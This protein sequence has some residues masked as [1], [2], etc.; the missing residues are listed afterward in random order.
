MQTPSSSACPLPT[1]LAINPFLACPQA[2]SETGTHQSTLVDGGDARQLSEHKVVS[3]WM[4]IYAPRMI[5][6]NGVIRYIA[7]SD[8]DLNP[9]EAT[10]RDILYKLVQVMSAVSIMKQTGMSAVEYASS[11]SPSRTRGAMSTCVHPSI[12][13]ASMSVHVQVG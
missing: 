2:E 13:H 11:K 5:T 12:L 8:T 4:K 9:D 10:R 3:Q 6:D 1:K 7:F